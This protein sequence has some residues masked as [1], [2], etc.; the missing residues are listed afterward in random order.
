MFTV[1]FFSAKLDVKAPSTTA[2]PIETEK[3]KVLPTEVSD[4]EEDGDEYYEDEDDEQIKKTP[5]MKKKVKVVDI[6]PKEVLVTP[7]LF[8]RLFLTFQIKVTIEKEEKPKAPKLVETSVQTDDDD[9]DLSSSSSSDSDEDED[10]RDI[11]Q[12][13]KQ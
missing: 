5:D 3:S 7:I 12:W 9:E 1:Y 2:K 6:K 11:P 8:P 13:N 10:V 4:S